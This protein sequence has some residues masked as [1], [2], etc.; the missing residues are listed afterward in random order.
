VAP[1]FT[2]S[3]DGRAFKLHDGFRA[4]L[5]VLFFSS[6]CA[7]PGVSTAVR[8]TFFCHYFQ[9]VKQLQAKGPYNHRFIYV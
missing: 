8:V 1:G 7:Q 6:V 5:G 9:I 3:C 2:R 4:V